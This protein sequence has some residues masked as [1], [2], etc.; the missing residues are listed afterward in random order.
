MPLTWVFSLNEKCEESISDMDMSHDG[1][2]MADVGFQ[3]V[4]ITHTDFECSIH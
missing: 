4:S 3:H 2:P 1:W